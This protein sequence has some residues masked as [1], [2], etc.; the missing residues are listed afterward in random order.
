MHYAYS[1][2]SL[3]KGEKR[4]AKK[5]KTE[6]KWFKLLTELEPEIATKKKFE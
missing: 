3:K 2:L 5:K 6:R 1:Y 4:K